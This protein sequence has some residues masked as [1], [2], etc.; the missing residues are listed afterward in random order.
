MKK[1]IPR[2]G[3]ATKDELNKLS[4][5]LKKNEEEVSLPGTTA[6]VLRARNTLKVRSTA[7]LPPTSP[8]AMVMYLKTTPI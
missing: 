2:Q 6:T 4:V 5:K 1:K 8:S 3:R 7:T